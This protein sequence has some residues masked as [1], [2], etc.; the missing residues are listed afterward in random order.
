MIE[1]GR[2]KSTGLSTGNDYHP[3]NVTGGFWLIDDRLCFRN[4]RLEFFAIGE[5]FDRMRG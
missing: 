1:R 4:G 3:T 5:H 2:K